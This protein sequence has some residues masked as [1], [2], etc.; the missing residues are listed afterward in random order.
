MLDPAIKEFFDQRKELWLKSNIKI[1]DSKEKRDEVKQ[2]CE[3]IFDLSEWLP[4]AAKRAGQISISTHPCTFSHPSAR[5]NKNGNVTSIIANCTSKNDGYLRTGNVNSMPDALG[6]AAALDVYK[7]LNIKLKDNLTIIQHI[8]GD[9]DQAKEILSSSTVTYEELKEGFLKMV[10]PSEENFITS[11]K[12]K[13]VFFPVDNGYHQL[14]ILTNSGI[15][16]ELRK[17]LDNMRFG[18]DIKVIRDL[19][20]ENKFCE[21]GYRE[22]RKLT[23]IGYGGTK[24]QN[25]SVL[26]NQNGGKAHLLLSIPPK[27]KVRDTRFPLKNVFDESLNWWDFKDLFA[28]LHKVMSIKVGENIPRQKILTALDNKIQEIVIKI[29]DEI[30][31][32]REV[33]KEQ[34]RESSSLPIS[35]QIWLCESKSEERGKNDFWLENILLDCIRWIFNSYSKSLG[36]KQFMLGN[37][38]FN[39]FKSRIEEWIAENKEFLL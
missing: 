17:R 11:S 39:D 13:Q 10:V 12:I 24:P 14:S 23:T 33:S 34:Y 32:L 4:N 30:Y 27:I 20:K 21:H 15:V 5:K 25:I 9:T 7:F 16:F 1:D 3:K 18:D 6:N 19:K 28:E 8:T 35:Q 22:I 29:M 26:N 2:A 36:D 31:L 37:S 38:E